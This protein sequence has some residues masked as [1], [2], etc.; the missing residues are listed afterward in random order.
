MN[1]KI[2]ENKINN[3]KKDIKKFYIKNNSLISYFTENKPKIY[4]G[5]IDI[6]CLFF[7]NLNEIIE[8]LEKNLNNNTISFSKINQFKYYCFKNS[9]IFELE[10]FS[11]DNNNEKKQIYYIS[12]FSKQ[13]NIK[14]NN[15]FIDILFPI[16]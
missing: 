4:K 5:P 13:G 8:M 10:I 1:K 12:F 16:R 7:S 2:D 11:I 14:L 15:K 9:D 6:R 3:L